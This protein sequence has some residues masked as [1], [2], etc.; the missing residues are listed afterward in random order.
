M[1]HMT[2]EIQ[3]VKNPIT[4]ENVAKIA[5]ETL[6]DFAKAVVDIERGIIALGGYMHADEEAFLL[7]NGSKQENLWGINLFPD[8]MGA[9]WIE[10][11][12]MINIRPRQGNR[13][14]G[15]ED[16][17]I[18]ERIFKV[19]ESLVAYPSPQPSPTEGEG[20]EKIL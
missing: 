20:A 9:A 19:V 6:G 11:D 2:D 16:P 14:R 17:G 7:Q 18:R 3:I 4:R 12:S 13:S 1:P 10:F 5:R 15:V 8:R